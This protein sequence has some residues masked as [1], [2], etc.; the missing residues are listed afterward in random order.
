MKALSR[1]QQLFILGVGLAAAAGLVYFL[2][3]GTVLR[4]KDRRERINFG[5]R[6]SSPNEIQ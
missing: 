4:I 5:L 1:S 3:R 2:V 6:R